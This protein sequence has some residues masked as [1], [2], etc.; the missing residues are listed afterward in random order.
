MAAGLAWNPNQDWRLSTNLDAVL[1]QSDASA[2]K[3]ADYVEGSFGYAYRPVDND[4]LNA[5]L[6]YSYFYDLPGLDQISSVTGAA[7]GPKQRSHIVS[8]DIN[9]NVVPWLTLGAKYGVRVGEVNYN[10]LGDATWRKSSA[11][12]AVG[13]ADVHIVKNWDA[14]LEG[15]ALAM[16]EAD[17]VDYGSVITVNR[18]VGDN[19]K[20]GLGYNF[21]RFSDDLRDL[22]MDD[23]G[24]HLNLVG[25]Y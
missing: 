13:R 21:G 22:V 12:L 17:T 5:L 9:Y 8:A 6:K 19:F 7:G 15:R 25:K 24:V 2:F 3:D 1:S 20:V 18:H 11:H 4:R 10:R 23:Q 16:P 14:T